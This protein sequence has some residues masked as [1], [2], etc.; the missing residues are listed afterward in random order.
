VKDYIFNLFHHP[1][2][3][4]GRI[5]TCGELGED[6]PLENIRA[7]YEAFTEFKWWILGMDGLSS[8]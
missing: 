5:I 7:M 8:T 1:G 3:S 6:V 4:D 2:T